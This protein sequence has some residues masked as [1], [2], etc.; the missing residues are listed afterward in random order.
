MTITK[1]SPEHEI[2]FQLPL[3]FRGPESALICKGLCVILVVR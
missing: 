1:K 3:T 2:T